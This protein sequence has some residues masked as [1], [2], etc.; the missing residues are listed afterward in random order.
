MSLNQLNVCRQ[1]NSLD[2]NDIKQQTLF[3]PN[4]LI[5][6]KGGSGGMDSKSQLHPSFALHSDSHLEMT[7]EVPQYHVLAQV[8]KQTVGAQND[9]ISILYFK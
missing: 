3:L 8:V 7:R 6:K 9:H 4:L 2:K 5:E 1:V